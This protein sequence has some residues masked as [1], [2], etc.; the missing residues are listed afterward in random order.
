MTA[1][2]LRNSKER[3]KGIEEEGGE[4]GKS[5]KSQTGTLSIL[6]REEH[7]LPPWHCPV[8]C[9]WSR[10]IRAANSASWRDTHRQRHTTTKSDKQRETQRGRYR[11]TKRD[12]TQKG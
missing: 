7:I 8:T 6:G 3:N 4:W 9:P 12:Q 10:R 1:W 2:R 5:T 11:Q